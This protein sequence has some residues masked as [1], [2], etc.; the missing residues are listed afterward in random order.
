MLCNKPLLRNELLQL[1]DPLSRLTRILL[2]PQALSLTQLAL[3]LA[4]LLA[5]LPRLP[6]S[7]KERPLWLLSRGLKRQLG[8][9]VRALLLL[10]RQRC[11][12]RCNCYRR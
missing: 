11:N 3:L 8:R 2:D 10:P 7:G 6:Q 4:L 9:R 12:C 5:R 1:L